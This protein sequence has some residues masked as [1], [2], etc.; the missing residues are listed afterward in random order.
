MSAQEYEERPRDGDYRLDD[1]RPQIV[2]LNET[3]LSK[4][5][6]DAEIAKVKAGIKHSHLTHLH[7]ISLTSK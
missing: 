4:E 6:V 7:V 2:Q 1:E 5:E 3:D